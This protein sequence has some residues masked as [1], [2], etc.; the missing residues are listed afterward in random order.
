MWSYFLSKDGYYNSLPLDMEL[1]QN[2][3]A[4]S[5]P[6]IIYCY[7]SMWDES[8]PV[9]CSDVSLIVWHRK[10]YKCRSIRLP[11]NLRRVGK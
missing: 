9:D 1:T 8:A 3:E 2:E 6:F 7:V 4:R 5:N 10:Y 11:D